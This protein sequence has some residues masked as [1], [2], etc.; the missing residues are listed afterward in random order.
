VAIEER[1]TVDRERA[2]PR[3]GKGRE[4]IIKFRSL[5]DDQLKDAKDRFDKALEEFID[6]GAEVSIHALSEMLSLAGLPHLSTS[7]V[8]DL[9][10]AQLSRLSKAIVDP[11]ADALFRPGSEEASLATAT[12]AR[13]WER[14][15]FDEKVLPPGID[16]PT[17]ADRLQERMNRE[18][19]EKAARE[20]V[21]EKR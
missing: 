18:I 3:L 4:D 8:K 17:V 9:Y 21:R 10:T 11:I 5:T 7:I 1:I 15:V 12:L 14:P 2:R 6:K 16:K 20:A 13:A 19:V